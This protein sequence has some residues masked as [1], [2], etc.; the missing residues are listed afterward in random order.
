MTISEPGFNITCPPVN[1]FVCCTRGSRI[2]VFNPTTG[3]MLTLPHVK[4]NGREIYARLGCDVHRKYVKQQEHLVLSLTSQFTR[5]RKIEITGDPYAYLEG[6]ICINGAIY[7]GVGHTKIARFDLRYEKI[8]FIQGPEDYNAISCYSTLTNY[9]G[10]LACVSHDSYC[11]SKMRLW[12]LQD[13]EKQEWSSIMTC[14]LACDKE[15]SL[16]SGETHTNEVV[17]VSRCLKSSNHF[18]VYY[19]D[20]IKESI[21]RRI[22][23]EIDGMVDYEFRR[24]RILCFPGHIENL[25][26]F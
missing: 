13:A 2:A 14:V 16:C 8:T 9:K 6:G 1:G 11:E 12:I 17:M 18:F 22:E 24:P 25:M 26:Y 7:Y 20:M 3:F 21:I 15:I 19:F 4:A 10:K 5:W 23:V